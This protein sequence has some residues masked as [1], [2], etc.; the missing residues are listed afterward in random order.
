ME[1][2]KVISVMKYPILNVKYKRFMDDKKSWGFKGKLSK[3]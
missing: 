1:K 3:N 2:P